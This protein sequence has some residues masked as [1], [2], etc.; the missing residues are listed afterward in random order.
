MGK[1][2]RVAIYIYI[3]N[4]DILTSFAVISRGSVRPDYRA[5]VM[6]IISIEA[7]CLSVLVHTYIC[8]RQGI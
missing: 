8:T 4:S 3:W 5:I 2:F 7:E 6:I 1:S